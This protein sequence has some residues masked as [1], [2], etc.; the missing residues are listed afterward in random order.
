MSSRP[1]KIF[2]GWHEP[3]HAY[4]ETWN[5]GRTTPPR[6]QVSAIPCP[7]APTI[8]DPETGV[9]LQPR[10]RLGDVRPLLLSL[11]NHYDYLTDWLARDLGIEEEILDRW[12]LHS[13]EIDA[14]SE[15][16]I[17]KLYAKTF[18]DQP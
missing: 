16:K 8:K 18:P 14:A 1:T 5:L 11:W 2:D 3:T 10:T 6:T 12:R 17:R 13:E 4:D 7:P 15:G 9:M